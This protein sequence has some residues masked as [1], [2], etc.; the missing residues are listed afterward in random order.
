MTSFNVH[1][2]T[3]TWLKKNLMLSSGFAYSDL[4]NNFSGSRIYGSD[5]D[6]GYVPNALSDFGYYD[7]QRRLAL[8]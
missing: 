3:E 7:L 8:A 5:F 6:V 1:A 2:F 4:D